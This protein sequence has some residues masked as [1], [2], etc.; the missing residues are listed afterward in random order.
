MKKFTKRLLAGALAL[1][2]TA[3]VASAQ[4]MA[5]S[6]ENAD[7]G[8][9]Y[10]LPDMSQTAWANRIGLDNEADNKEV[11]I[12]RYNTSINL[13]S[14]NLC[15][16]LL[17][18]QNSDVA[19]M[20]LILTYNSMD[21]I[22]NGFGKGIR[23]SYSRQIIDNKDGTYT[24]IDKTGTQYLFLPSGSG[25]YQDCL[26]RELSVSSQYGY[27]LT[28]SGDGAY[29]FDMDGKLTRVLTGGLSTWRTTSLTYGPDGKL[30][31][32]YNGLGMY[33][34]SLEYQFHYSPKGEVVSISIH[35]GDNDPAPL[36]VSFEY[37][38]NGL[39][40]VINTDG[41][42]FN[43]TTDPE[44]G[45]LSGIDLYRFTYLGDGTGRV[46]S[47]NENQYLYGNFQTIVT[48]ASGKMKLYQFDDNGE[49]RQ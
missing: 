23:T 30:L 5:Y 42:T 47:I 4:V 36:L 48:D 28:A 26:G 44:T 45:L 46:A 41:T 1:T 7:A 21:S 14:G 19:P 2:L 6:A 13:F 18:F 10:A 43:C 16:S 31:S 22:D 24:Y 34:K 9:A 27:T 8:L 32:V 37:D 25:V 12:P 11:L 20:D 38:A 40:R 3:S 39:T 15:S 29:D 17:L 35:R 33:S 49:F